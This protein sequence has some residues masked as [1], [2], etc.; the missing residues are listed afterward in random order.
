MSNNYKLAEHKDSIS[1]LLVVKP[2]VY[3]DHR[4]ENFEGFG[5]LQ[6]IAGYQTGANQ[7]NGPANP[8]AS[9]QYL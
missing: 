9:G 8:Q 7:E 6:N 4:G 2:E 3:F 5:I 1:D